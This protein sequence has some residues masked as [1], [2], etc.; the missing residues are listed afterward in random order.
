MIKNFFEI[1]VF[2]L[3]TPSVLID[4]TPCLECLLLQ[5]GPEPVELSLLKEPKELTR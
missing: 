5:G 3:K 2:S 4:F 1:T